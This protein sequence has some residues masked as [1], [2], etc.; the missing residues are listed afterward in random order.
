M[1][2]LSAQSSSAAHTAVDNLYDSGALDQQVLAG[3]SEMPRC[4][5]FCV[6]QEK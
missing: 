5:S 3:F 1:E 4:P 6:R 2:A